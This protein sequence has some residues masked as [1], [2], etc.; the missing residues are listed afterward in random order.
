MMCSLTQCTGARVAAMR[1]KQTGLT[2]VEL[3]V[4]MTLGLLVVM[5]ATALLLST[6]SGYI[7]QDEIARL[8]DTGRYAIENVARAV[9]QAA[10]ENWDKDDAPVVATATFSANVA[11]LDAHG[12]KE[13]STGIDSPVSA[14]VNG[15]DILALR[16]F[17]A[18]AGS[19][20]DGSILNCAG[21]GVG[22]A[23]TRESADQSRGWSIFYVGVTSGEPELR[24]KYHGK[25]SWSSD[26]IARGVESFQ[27]L[28]GIDTDGDG[29]ANQYVTASAINTLDDALILVGA[30][31]NAKSIDKNRKTNWKKIV[32]I[33]IA[34]LVRG[35]QN[36]RTDALATQYDL[37]GKAYSDANAAHDRGTRIKESDLPAAVRNRL[38]KVFSVTIQLRNQAAGGTT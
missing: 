20:G 17:G 10:Y 15:S 30:D 8:Q 24:C 4:S 3:M 25:T 21:F 16:Y 35:S 27:V 9:R 33:K 23:A 32:V 18:G 22:A 11:G 6:K 29:L 12:L 37:F 19:G 28:Y 26:A 5:A 14:S 36:A 13:S 7:T 34:L 38:R 1:A 2:I 31:T